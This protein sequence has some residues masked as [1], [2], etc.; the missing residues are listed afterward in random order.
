MGGSKELRSEK[1]LVSIPAEVETR[2]YSVPIL[3]EMLAQFGETSSY[4][5]NRNNVIGSF[6]SPLASGCRPHTIGWLIIAIVIQAFNPPAFL[7]VAHVG[8]EV[9]E[10]VEPAF[11]NSYTSPPIMVKIDGGWTEAP[12]FHAFPYP[13]NS[14]WLPAVA[15]SIPMLKSTRGELLCPLASTGLRPSAHNI[16]KRNGSYIP[17]IAVENT[18]PAYPSRRVALRQPFFSCNKSSKS[19]TDDIY[20]GRHNGVR[21]L[22]MFSGGRPASTGARC[23]YLQSKESVNT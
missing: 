1:R 15:A 5:S 22:F 13:I 2:P 14:L 17:A 19:A 11:A 3:S 20:F 21:S 4:S 9:L 8:D 16:C 10:R 12:C 18:S 7:S 23:D 6:I